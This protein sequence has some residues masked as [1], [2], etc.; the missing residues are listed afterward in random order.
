MRKLL[1]TLTM[2]IF[3]AGA[4]LAETRTVIVVD[5]EDEPIA[6]A[7]VRVSDVVRKL[8]RFETDDEGRATLEDLPV[9]SF[10]LTFTADGFATREMLLTTDTLADEFKVHLSAK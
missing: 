3:V 4:A 9:G 1:A 6:G 7:H 10:K 2:L 5:A 8:E